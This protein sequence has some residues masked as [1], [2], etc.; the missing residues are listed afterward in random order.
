MNTTTQKTKDELQTEYNVLFEELRNSDRKNSDS[1]N[2]DS[3]I[4]KMNANKEKVKELDKIILLK[5][6]NVKYS[7]LRSMAK[8]AY[9]C[10]TPTEDI[11]TDSGYFHKTKVKKYP[12][13]AALE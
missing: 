13:I 5:Q 4:K 6:V 12:K 7:R 1:K 3:I 2:S 8:Q 9:E 10:E 11:T